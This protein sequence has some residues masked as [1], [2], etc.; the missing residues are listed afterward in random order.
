[1]RIIRPGETVEWS[2]NLLRY[3]RIE[4]PGEYSVEIQRNPFADKLR[5]KAGPI[6]LRLT[7]P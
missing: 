5:I 2:L 7:R 6:R 1:M 4:E 3:A